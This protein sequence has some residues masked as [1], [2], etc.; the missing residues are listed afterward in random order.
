MSSFGHSTIIYK[1]V[2]SFSESFFRFS[3]VRPGVQT[4]RDTL[5][6]HRQNI[7]AL[8]TYSEFKAEVPTSGIYQDQPAVISQTDETSFKTAKGYY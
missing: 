4:V 6:T 7:D 2:Q 5:I 1:T 8:T 3:A